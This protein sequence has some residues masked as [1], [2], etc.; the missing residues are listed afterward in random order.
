MGLFARQPP[1]PP[2]W[3]PFTDGAEHQEFV[4]LVEEVLH[5]AGMDA[6]PEEDGAAYRDRNSDTVLWLDNLAILCARAERDA[7]AE[8]VLRHVT[9][10]L[11]PD[12]M[13]ELV[14]DPDAFRAAVR[15][16]LYTEAAVAQ[17]EGNLP[18]RTAAAGLVETV[19]ID[20]PETVAIV[21]AEAYAPLGLSEED[22]FALG[23]DN[24]RTDGPPEVTI[25]EGETELH[26]AESQS[27]FTASWALI[28]D[29]L[30]DVPEHGAL[31]VVPSRHV[32]VAHPVRDQ[33]AVS[34]VQVLLGL[35]HQH[36]AE[37]PG[38]L[39][40]DLYW[41]RDGNLTLLPATETDDGGLAF[42]PP[43]EFVEV[44]NAVV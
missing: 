7:W 33:T 8:L 28:L 10:M 13:S 4:S 5:R 30:I 27:F 23:R 24:V 9:A 38:A 14:D 22:L 29:E 18:R 17:H 35:A 37:A 25:H 43:D 3:S 31:V 34:A 36:F 42:A 19:V 6:V 26:V 44:L 41:Y 32:L 16:R 15:V 2:A 1:D 11:H 39:S 20:T 40:P 12:P 21:D